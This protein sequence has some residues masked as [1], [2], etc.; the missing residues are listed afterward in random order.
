MMFAFSRDR[1][2]PG[3]PALEARSAATAS[4]TMA[5]LAIGVLVVGC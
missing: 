1:A 3:P 4:R 2:V 5:V